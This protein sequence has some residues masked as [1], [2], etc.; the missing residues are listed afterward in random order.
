MNKLLTALV[1]SIVLPIASTSFA[2]D[3]ANNNDETLVNGSSDNPQ[4]QKQ[5]KRIDQNGKKTSSQ[6]ARKTK[7]KDKGMHIKDEV[8]DTIQNEPAD[9]MEIKS[10]SPKAN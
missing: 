7:S 6:K 3:A 10:P 4:V 9:A 5:Q 8:T 1:F 2:A